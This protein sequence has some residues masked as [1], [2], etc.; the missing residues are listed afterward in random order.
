[1]TEEHATNE[2]FF[3]IYSLGFLLCKL[4]HRRYSRYE[5]EVAMQRTTVVPRLSSVYT[6]G[7]CF[8]WFLLVP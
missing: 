1:M 7:S 3:R 2:Y 8:L 6:D 5:L 4:E